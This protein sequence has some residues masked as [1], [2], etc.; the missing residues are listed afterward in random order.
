MPLQGQDAQA[1]WGGLMPDAVADHQEQVLLLHLHFPCTQS[2]LWHSFP[3]I[4]LDQILPT[5][6]C[7]VALA[8]LSL[9]TCTEIIQPFLLQD[10]P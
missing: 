2:A 8:R 5:T 7:S 3:C 1:F 10:L 6:L 4:G 9:S